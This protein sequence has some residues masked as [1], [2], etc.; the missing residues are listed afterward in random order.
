MAIIK[1][2]TNIKWYSIFITTISGEVT[3]NYELQIAKRDL[4]LMHDNIACIV[5]IKL[6]YSL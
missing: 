3:K 1:T 4:D 6:L 5:V 2:R